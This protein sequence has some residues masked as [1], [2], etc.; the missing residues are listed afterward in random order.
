MNILFKLT[1]LILVL[2]SATAK[3]GSTQEQIKITH[4]EF[5]HPLVF[6]VTLPAGYEKDIG[7]SY[8][9]MFDLHSYSD[10]YL[11]GMHDWMSHNGQWPWLKTIIVTPAAGNRAAMLFDE[12]GK[13]TPLLDLIDEKLLPKVVQKYRTNGFKIMSGFRMNGSVVLSAL[14]NKPDMF[15]AY[16][17]TSPELKDDFSGLLSTAPKKLAKLG[18]KPRFLL[19][20]HGAN[21]KETHQITDYDALFSIL[22][23]DAPHKLDWHYEN[24]ANNYHMSLPLI[25]VI[26][27]IEKL[28]NDIHIGLAPTSEIS[29]KGTNAIIKHY[30]YLSQHKYGF[31]VSPKHSINALG[32][33]LL[34]T[35]HQ[36]AI[37][38][39]KQMIDLYPA[40]AYSHHNLA[41]AYEKIGDF[42]NAV[43]HQQ[44]AVKLANN[45]LT[46][47]KNRHQKFLA[48]YLSK[49]DNALE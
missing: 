38:I 17:A 16:I 40:D 23:K 7:K 27:A 30:Q 10:T 49:S 44:D 20:S 12:T 39:F 45:M 4:A 36:A 15:N 34:K 31:E 33:H 24:F 1:L 47:H 41:N 42:E 18:D 5:S 48:D 11:S 6:N 8:V 37:Q 19:F 26:T 22:K 14:I 46:W 43:K 9:L 35:S 13:T 29:Q 21:V 25:S 32:Y 3:A 2:T 28:F